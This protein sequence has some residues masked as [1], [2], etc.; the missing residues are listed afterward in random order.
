V[1]RIRNAKTRR[2]HRPTT[3]I[4]DLKVAQAPLL[5]QKESHQVRT[6]LESIMRR[7]LPKLEGDEFERFR[8]R[9]QTIPSHGALPP[10]GSPIHVVLLAIDAELEQAGDAAAAADHIVELFRQDPG[11]VGTLCAFSEALG[12]LSPVTQR[13]IDVDPTV[14]I[15]YLDMNW[16]SDVNYEA[17]A[18][19][20]NTASSQ[21]DARIAPTRGQ[22]RTRPSGRKRGRA[23]A[24]VA[25]AHA[26]A[27]RLENFEIGEL[28]EILPSIRT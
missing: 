8:R 28:M 25:V 2:A 19:Q 3:S 26:Q 5:V 12:D 23:K 16:I 1:V 11:A 22:R 13:P 21:L 27:D 14:R 17:V 7:M 20:Y 10:R 15:N 9:P 18:V 24:A 4:D 6:I